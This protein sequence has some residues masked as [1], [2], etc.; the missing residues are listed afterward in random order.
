MSKVGG[1]G[2]VAGVCFQFGCVGR[3][4]VGNRKSAHSKLTIIVCNFIGN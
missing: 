2:G 3:A 4:Q 1:G